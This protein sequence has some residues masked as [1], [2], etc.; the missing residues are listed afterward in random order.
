[1]MLSWLEKLV[2]KKEAEKNRDLTPKVTA[3]NVPMN[4]RTLLLLTPLGG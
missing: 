1:M 2:L 4:E 3:Q